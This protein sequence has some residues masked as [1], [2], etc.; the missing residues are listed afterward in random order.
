[1]VIEAGSAVDTSPWI[2][3]VAAVVFAG[4][5]GE[6]VNQ[7]IANVLTGKVNP[8]GRLSETFPMC[9]EDTPTQREMGSP[10][11]ERYAEGV[12]VGYRYYTT[13]KIPVMFP[14]G[15][16]LS[17]SSFSYSDFSVENLGGCKYR[18]SVTVKNDSDVDGHDTVQLYVKNVDMCVE[19]PTVELRRFEKVFIPAG[20]SR[21]VEFITDKDC[22]EYFNVCYDAWHVDAGR[23]EL[24]INRD[25]NTTVF[26]EKIRI[27]N[28]DLQ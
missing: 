7:A 6:S 2:D 11:A 5:G 3:K 20:E 12:L 17:Y 24:C 13:K 10:Y 15:Y 4:F 26:C 19:R 9:L 1:M 21:K 14:F 16:G 18:V 22:F 27:E 28:G 8:S 25:A 23:Y